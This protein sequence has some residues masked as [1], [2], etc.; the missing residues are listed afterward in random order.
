V[1][2]CCIF[3][4]F[5]SRHKHYG[6]FVISQSILHM[7][8]MLTCTFGQWKSENNKFLQSSWIIPLFNQLCEKLVLW[9]VCGPVVFA[10]LQCWFEPR[11]LDGASLGSCWWC[12]RA[13]RFGQRELSLPCAWKSLLSVAF[14]VFPFLRASASRTSATATS[15]SFLEVFGL[16]TLFS[17]NYHA[18]WY[19]ESSQIRWRASHA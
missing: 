12:H 5:Q 8:D 17:F 13:R 1:S 2:K 6:W 7:K 3:H 16:P 10:H 4:S 9:S 19:Q 11:N 14:L 15:L 18:N